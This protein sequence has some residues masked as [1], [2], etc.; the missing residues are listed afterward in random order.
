MA[1]SPSSQVKLISNHDKLCLTGKQ[2]QHA[3]EAVQE[4]KPIQPYTSHVDI[5]QL[6]TDDSE[7]NPYHK[8]LCAMVDTELFQE[9]R[10]E[11]D[12]CDINWS[13]LST[14]VD[15]TTHRDLDIP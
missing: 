9:P 6:A 3:Y 11:M 15:D 12:Q 10:L 2:A 1:E 14:H 8:G 5:D 4:G 7:V 13:I